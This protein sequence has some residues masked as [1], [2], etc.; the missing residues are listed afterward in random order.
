MKELQL[1]IDGMSC[2]HCVATVRKAL[3]AVPGVQVKDV[4]VGTAHLNIDSDSVTVGSI[5]DAVQDVGY[6]AQEA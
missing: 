2:S 4:Q 3:A 5:I 1:I 6:E